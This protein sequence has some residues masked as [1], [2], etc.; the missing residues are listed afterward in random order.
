MS[1][2]LDKVNR[3]EGQEGSNDIVVPSDPSETE[4]RKHRPAAPVVN[5]AAE[6]SNQIP[7]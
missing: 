2:L 1:L 7:K 6:P 4:D 5:A 3:D